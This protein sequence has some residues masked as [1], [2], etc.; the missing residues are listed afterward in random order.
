VIVLG[1]DPGKLGGLAFLDV[2]A[3]VEH[4]LLLEPMPVIQAKAGKGRVEYDVAEIVRLVNAAQHRERGN[5]VA[6]LERL[7]PMPLEKGGTIANFNRGAASHLFVGIFA[8]LGVRSPGRPAAVATRDARGDLGRRH[9]ATLDHRGT[10]VLPEHVVSGDG[11]ES[12]AERRADRCG[13][14]R[15]V[16]PAPARGRARRAARVARGLLMSGCSRC[17]SLDEGKLY[18]NVGKRGTFCVDCWEAIGRPFPQDHATPIDLEGQ[19]IATRE[20]M[21]KRGGTSAHLVRKGLT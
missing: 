20:R 21:L 5:I 1:V 9:E 19:E 17:G 11:A 2:G 4:A 14:T 3:T 7:H 15:G 12:Q 6:F 18:A 16:W 10:A 13:A 8:A